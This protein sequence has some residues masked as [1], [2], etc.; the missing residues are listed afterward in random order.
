MGDQGTRIKIISKHGFSFN[1]LLSVEVINDNL[2]V[3]W[4]VHPEKLGVE[5]VYL[6]DIT[7]SP[8]SCHILLIFQGKCFHHFW[9]C[10]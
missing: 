9:W 3:N 1:S 8:I 7:M 6:K 4:R 10:D 5:M 2:C